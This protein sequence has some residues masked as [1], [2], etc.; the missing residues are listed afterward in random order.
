MPKEQT[1]PYAS[2]TALIPAAEW[3]GG[4]R[5]VPYD[6][7]RHRVLTT[8]DDMS[9][10]PLMV[11][12]RVVGAPLMD[13]EGRWMTL[14]PGFPD[15]S[16]GYAYV[17]ASILSTSDRATRISPGITPTQPLSVPIWLK[18]SGRRMRCGV[19]LW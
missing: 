19:P 6:P 11:F 12:E 8:H 14:L 5:R 18:R 4:G 1:V 7:N 2:K 10:P 15:G 9:T 16:Y 13:A 3:F 17:N